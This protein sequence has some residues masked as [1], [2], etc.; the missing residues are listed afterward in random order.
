MSPPC[1]FAD[2]AESQAAVAGEQVGVPDR[3]VPAGRSN[4]LFHFVYRQIV[5]LPSARLGSLVTGKQ[6]HWVCRDN[7]FAHS[8]I[9][10]GHERALM[11]E[12][13]FGF[14]IF[15]FGCLI[16]GLQIFHKGDAE[17]LAHVPDLCV[18]AAHIGENAI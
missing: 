3:F 6:V 4:Q 5:S 8:D 7:S 16:S 12:G 13:G 18:A 1:Q 11:I 9:Q 17:L 14:E 2:I 10:G 15:S